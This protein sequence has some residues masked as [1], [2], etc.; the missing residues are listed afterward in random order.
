M[1]EAVL[2]ERSPRAQ[3]IVYSI[4][5]NIRF[6]RLC[7]HLGHS[8]FVFCSYADPHY[9]EPYTETLK[10]RVGINQ[11]TLQRIGT[12]AVA[13][14]PRRCCETGR[15]GDIP[16]RVGCSG[17]SLRPSGE[18]VGCDRSGPDLRRVLVRTIWE[19]YRGQSMGPSRVAVFCGVRFG[20]DL[21]SPQISTLMKRSKAIQGPPSGSELRRQRAHP[22]I[23]LA[24]Q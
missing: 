8:D 19:S 4:P 13:L 18:F 6:L 3:P 9:G 12:C 20:D 22:G 14:F 1:Q 23:S 15:A 17:L 24:K 21:L 5:R 2:A 7:P 10:P 16:A 11:H